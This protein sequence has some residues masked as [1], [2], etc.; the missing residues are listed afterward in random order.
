[1]A[2]IIKRKKFD[3]GEKGNYWNYVLEEN[4]GV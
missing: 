2:I 3:V 1:M 4:I